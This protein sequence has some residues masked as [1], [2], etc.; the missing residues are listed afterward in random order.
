MHC[1]NLI[2][3]DH[4]MMAQFEILDP[5]A[6]GHDP[7]GTHCRGRRPICQA[8]L[9]ES[10]CRPAS[11]RQHSA[12]TDRGRRRCCYVAALRRWLTSWPRQLTTRGGRSPA[13]SSV[14]SV[15]VQLIFAGLLLRGYRNRPLVLTGIWLTV[16]VIL[17]YVAS[18]TV[19]IP[20]APPVP[21][22]GGRWVIGR[23]AIPNGAK[24]VGPLDM[25]TLAR[26][27]GARRRAH[28]STLPSRSR[29][30]TVNCLM[31]IGLAVVGRRRLRMLFIDGHDRAAARHR[32]H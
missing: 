17:V 30:R 21:F 13:S 12:E 24:H 10:T 22:H 4:D 11:R 2:H 31:W 26:R 3:E 20:M 27:V 7:R 25:F 23:S 19:G 16:G 32:A 29:V 1:H 8:T 5:K 9:C 18:R 14:C 28:V 6:A 15:S